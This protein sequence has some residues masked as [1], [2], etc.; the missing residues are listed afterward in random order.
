MINDN[1][2]AY[3]SNWS[4]PINIPLGV[5]QSPSPSATPS[6]SP[7][8]VAF[9]KSSALLPMTPSMSRVSSST[10]FGIHTTNTFTPTVIKSPPVNIESAS[11]SQSVMTTSGSYILYHALLFYVQLV[12]IIIITYF[13]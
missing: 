3:V 11:P 4:A 1:Y 7:S 13:P 5:P 9:S 12:L 10:N 6:T 8:T 2:A